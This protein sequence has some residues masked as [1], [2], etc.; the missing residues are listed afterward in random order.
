MATLKNLVDETT[1]IKN[2]LKTCHTDLRN[3]LV[4]LG[5]E[6]NVNDKLSDLV[7]KTN[8]IK[9]FPSDWYTEKCGE[10]FMDDVISEGDAIVFQTY[11]NWNEGIEP[12]IN[13][14]D[15]VPKLTTSYHPYVVSQF[16]HDGEFLIS[17]STE[18]PF[19]KVDGDNFSLINI[20][21]SSLTSKTN[22]GLD[23]VAVRDD[24]EY[25]YIEPN[26]SNNP[27]H[28][29]YKKSG[30]TYT[31]QQSFS[32]M[33]GYM[34]DAVYGKFSKSKKFLHI[35][36]SPY[37]SM[38]TSNPTVCNYFELN[39]GTK[40][41]EP[42]KTSP[43]ILGGLDTNSVKKNCVEYLERFNSFIL[44]SR[45]S[46][47]HGAYLISFDE[48]NK[49]YTTVNAT[50]YFDLCPS[51]YTTAIASS[52]GGD[53][54]VW[55]HNYT[56]IYTYRYNEDTSKYEK[57]PKSDFVVNGTVYSVKFD[58]SGNYFAVTYSNSPFLDI[59][60]WNGEK[61]EKT[62]GLNYEF[63]VIPTDIAFSPNGRFLY[64]GLNDNGKNNS[65]VFLTETK[66]IV[67]KYK[68][69]SLIYYSLDKKEIGIALETK[70]KGEQIKVNTM[71]KLKL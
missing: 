66:D 25:I 37:S 21:G 44:A 2:E 13:P 53:F 26:G 7:S 32:S 61:F 59:F 6:C 18:T 42:C 51:K 9:K 43:K 62:A 31:L 58:N 52:K 30:D 34:P 47:S 69:T 39:E 36:G 49:K 35:L 54:F 60:K 55:V 11:G 5:V 68:N 20:G 28:Y 1:N 19:Y 4:S 57:I 64:V 50:S 63:T 16:T 17:G 8:E 48:E 15:V 71:P 65:K 23:L 67:T 27:M 12:L 41:Y 33:S 46:L 70:S 10:V 3:S 56:N 22:D 40:R 14:F 45:D 24:C 29:I 38:A